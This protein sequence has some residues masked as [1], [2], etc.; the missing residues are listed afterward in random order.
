MGVS[1]NLATEEDFR[2]QKTNTKRGSTSGQMWEVD[3]GK[4][5]I[6]SEHQ[7]T[8]KQVTSDP[9]ERSKTRNTARPWWVALETMKELEDCLKKLDHGV[10]RKRRN[11]ATQQKAEINQLELGGQLKRTW[12]N[13]LRDYFEEAMR[14]PSSALP[15][16]ANYFVRTTGQ[17]MF[18]WNLVE[19]ELETLTLHD[20]LRLGGKNLEIYQ[21]LT[22]HV[23]RDNSGLSLAKR[24]DATCF[25]RWIMSV[26]TDSNIQPY[27][28]RA[29]GSKT[30]ERRISAVILNVYQ[31][32]GIEKEDGSRQ[33]LENQGKLDEIRRFYNK[34]FEEGHDVH[35][36]L[37]SAGE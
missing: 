32:T 12:Q 24:K 11:W 1:T 19:I 35:R 22:Q 8:G 29:I 15:L 13:L 27:K 10:S 7:A 31:S 36:N 26:M 37:A 17:L 21:M 2:P 18:T 6:S 4:E 34:K 25:L 16:I 5:W 20:K 30:M 23:A 3:V 28:Q 9:L 33:S 14:T